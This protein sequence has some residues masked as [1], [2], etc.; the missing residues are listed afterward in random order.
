MTARETRVETRLNCSIYIRIAATYYTPR[1]SVRHR[2]RP[3]AFLSLLSKTNV[4]GP[5]FTRDT[6]IDAPKTPS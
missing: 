3:Y 1:S 4:T 6:A 2:P 5:S